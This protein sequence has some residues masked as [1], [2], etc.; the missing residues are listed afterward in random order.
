MSE[1]EDAKY[2]GFFCTKCPHDLVTDS[3]EVK[4]EKYLKR[5][6]LYPEVKYEKKGKNGKQKCGTTF[7]ANFLNNKGGHC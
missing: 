7:V 5:L 3:E 4:R 6:M 2:Y 1:V